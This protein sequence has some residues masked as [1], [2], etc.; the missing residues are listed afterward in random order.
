MFRGGPLVWPS[1]PRSTPP[2]SSTGA[3]DASASSPR[4]ARSRISCGCSP[5][6]SR[7]E[8][9]RHPVDVV[10]CVR[11]FR[12]PHAVGCPFASLHAA[13]HW[14]PGDNRS[15]SSRQ[16]A[17]SD[18]AGGPLAEP[19]EGARREALRRVSG[20]IHLGLEVAVGIVR[21]EQWKGWAVKGRMER[22]SS[23]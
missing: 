12:R 5:S 10:A 3:P 22:P 20:H 19:V 4:G 15:V 1:P 9:F 6:T 23:A 18:C 13:R 17:S 11:F 14:R 8:R 21:G 7:G 2:P 16:R